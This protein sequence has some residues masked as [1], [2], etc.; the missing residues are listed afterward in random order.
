[1]LICEVFIRYISDNCGE[2]ITNCEEATLMERRN[3]MVAGA[4]KS[5][6]NRLRTFVRGM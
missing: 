6:V 1:V 3:V 5:G 4:V 2:I